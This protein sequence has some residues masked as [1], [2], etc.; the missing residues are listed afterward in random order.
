MMTRVVG[1][2]PEEVMIGMQVTASVGTID[3]APA[4][5]F[6]PAEDPA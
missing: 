3:D 4:V 5:L 2:A 6:H 1:I